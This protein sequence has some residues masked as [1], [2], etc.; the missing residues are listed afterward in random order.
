LTSAEGVLGVLSLARRGGEPPRA[1]ERETL[2]AIRNQIAVAVENTRLLGEL[3]Q[4]QAQR[5]LDRMKAE[6]M[7]AVSHELRTP[8]G[9]IKGYATA[10]TL[11]EAAVD[12]ATRREFLR[13]IEE[14]TDKLQKLIEDLL[15]SGRLQAGRFQVQPRVV[16]LAELLEGPLSRVPA[17][18]EQG[19]HRLELP[20][21]PVETAVVADPGRVEQV[22]Y[23]LLDNAA[24]YA[25]PD[26]PMEIGITVGDG[27]VAISVTDHGPGIPPEELEHIFE[28]FY[29]GT[30]ARRVGAGGTGLGLA[31]CKGIVEAHGGRLWAESVLGR[32]TAFFFTLPLAVPRNPN[33][34]TLVRQA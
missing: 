25:P 22:L 9:I 1:E 21:V 5:E 17:L 7:S 23:N 6:F 29:R 26:T 16:H 31:I 2:E 13:V 12:L 28:P 14:E 4:L 34:A 27:Q 18:M 8:L 30:S 15:D 10:L 19:G 32:G 33:E 24:R 3:T 11:N 20:S